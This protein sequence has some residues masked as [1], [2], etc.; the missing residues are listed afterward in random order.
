[1]R[2]VKKN[3][4]LAPK[5]ALGHPKG[6]DTQALNKVR[7]LSRSLTMAFFKRIVGRLATLG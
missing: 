6:L 3:E 4:R 5:E 2:L 1:M 7:H